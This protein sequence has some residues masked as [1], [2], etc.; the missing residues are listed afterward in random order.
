MTEHVDGS[1]S[2]REFDFAGRYE[3]PRGVEDITWTVVP[4]TRRSPPGEAGFEPHTTIRGVRF[5]GY[6]FDG[7]SAGDPAAATEA[8]MPADLLGFGEPPCVLSG[9]LPCVI[10]RDGLR[11]TSTIS[12]SLDVGPVS[13]PNAKILRLSTVVDQR[14]CQV[15]DTWFEDGMQR[16]ERELPDGVTFVCCVTCLFSDYSPGGHGLL[17]MTC[18]R[19]A[20]QQYLAVKSKQEYWQVPRTEEVMETHICPEY[21]RRAPGTGYRG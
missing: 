13:D 14:I 10:E 8:G 1:S 4:S 7:L 9:D 17:G 2:L 5:W 12:F 18:H 6:D 20:K 21:E 11:S 15:T 16:L 3:D 19:R